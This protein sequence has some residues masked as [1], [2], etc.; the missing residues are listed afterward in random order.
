MIATSDSLKSQWKE[1]PGLDKQKK[2]QSFDN[3]RQQKEDDSE[4]QWA[5]ES[6]SL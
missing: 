6:G 3:S 4:V 2:K 5:E 1:D